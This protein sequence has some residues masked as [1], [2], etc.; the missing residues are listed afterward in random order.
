MN[1]DKVFLPE[2]NNNYIDN[3]ENIE[4]VEVTGDSSCPCCVY[5]TIPNKG[6]AL[7]YICPV[8]MLEIDLFIK[9]DNESSD[10]NSGLSLKQARENYKKF[11]AVLQRLKQYCREPKDYE[12]W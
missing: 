11:G 10:L 7:A 3:N 1:Y 2:V 9:D 5:I 12:L 6:D 8:C 4:V